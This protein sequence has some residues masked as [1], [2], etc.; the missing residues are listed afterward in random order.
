MAA[1]FGKLITDL[2]NNPLICGLEPV[3]LMIN[4]VKTK[5]APINVCSWRGSYELGCIVPGIKPVMAHEFLKLLQWAI[6]GTCFRGWKG[7][8]YYFNKNTPVWFGN[9]G[10]YLEV[11]CVEIIQEES[12]VYLVI[13][14]EEY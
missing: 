13:N 6:N 12:I 1:T 10:E 8:E 14:N 2:T 9:E 5:E 7:G 4:G 3:Y 11:A